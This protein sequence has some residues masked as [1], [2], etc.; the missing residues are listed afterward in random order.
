MG[1]SGRSTSC[2]S[3]DFGVRATA[4]DAAR[5]RF[6]TI[7]V[8]DLTRGISHENEADTDSEWDRVGVRRIPCRWLDYPSEPA[9][10]RFGHK[11]DMG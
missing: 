2:S 8:D 4:T 9:P 1:A 6:E 11:F 7:V 3:R 10:V 5:G